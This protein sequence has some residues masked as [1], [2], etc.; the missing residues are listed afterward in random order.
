MMHARGSAA[1]YFLV[2]IALLALTALSLGLS[3][4]HLGSTD[5]AVALVIAAV[6]ATLVVLFFM[7]LAEERFSVAMLPMLGLFLFLLLV[8]LVVVD[9]ATRTTYPSAPAPD[10]G[11]APG[12]AD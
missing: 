11:D 6:K 3:F 12:R 7:H 4:A 8:V 5:V 2:W 9:V 10:V 1:R